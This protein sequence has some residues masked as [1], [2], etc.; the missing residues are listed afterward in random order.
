MNQPQAGNVRHIPFGKAA[1][2]QAVDQLGEV[3]GVV[4]P[5]G[6]ALD[7]VKVR[8]LWALAADGD[9]L[10]RGAGRERDGRP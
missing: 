6:L 5:L 7:A 1:A 8:A 2:A 10:R 3:G 9:E 4:Q